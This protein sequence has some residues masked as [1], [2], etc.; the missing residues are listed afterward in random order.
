MKKILIFVGVLLFVY[1]LWS[2]GVQDKIL[3][4]QKEKQRH[5]LEEKKHLRAADSGYGNPESFLD[6]RRS[7]DLARQER[8]KIR[9]I[10]REIE[11]LKKDHPK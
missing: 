5:L 9:H 4:L 6:I 3:S 2:D 8:D 10:E 11:K 7:Y 1:P